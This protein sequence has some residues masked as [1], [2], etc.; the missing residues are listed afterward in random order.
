MEAA[1]EVAAAPEGTNVEVGARVMGLVNSGGYAEYVV[2]P[3]DRA[4]II[5]EHLSFEEAAAI[6]EVFLTAYQTLFWLGELKN[7]ETVL[8]HAGGSGV[9]T[10]AIQLANKQLA[11]A[12]IITTAGSQEKLGIFAVHWELM[13]VSIIKNS[14]LRKRF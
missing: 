2:M 13:S 5:P 6:P 7:Q 14:H 4:M 9:G 11:N 10:A 12:N 8:I 1:G 3:A